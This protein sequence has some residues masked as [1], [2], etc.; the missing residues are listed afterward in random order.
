MT[1]LPA[2]SISN[3]AHRYDSSTP[4]AHNTIKEVDALNAI[5]F[6]KFISIIPSNY[7]VHILQNNIVTYGEAVEKARLLQDCKVN[8]ELIC[9]R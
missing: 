1:M 7:R 3:L 9:Q 8:N 6:N 5:K 2:E 4:K